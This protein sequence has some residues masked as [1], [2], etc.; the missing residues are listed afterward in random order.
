MKLIILFFTYCFIFNSASQDLVQVQKLYS[1][2][3]QAELIAKKGFTVV[4]KE[5]KEVVRSLK[6]KFGNLFLYEERDFN[7]PKK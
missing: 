3:Y 4:I 5:S 2:I 6:E 1:N 7:E